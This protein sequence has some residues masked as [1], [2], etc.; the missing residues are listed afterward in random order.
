[1]CADWNYAKY[2]SCHR[3]GASVERAQVQHNGSFCYE[4]AMGWRKRDRRRAAEAQGSTSAASAMDVDG[5]PPAG[6]RD[7]PDAQRAEL[8]SN[9][10]SLRAALG[11]LAKGQPGLVV[12]R[13]G[14]Q[15]QL[16]ELER[17]RLAL[18][19]PEARFQSALD[20]HRAASTKRDDLEGRVREARA[21][22]ADLE[23]QLRAACT[24]EVACG[25]AAEAAR[26]A[27]VQPG[28]PG[29]SGGAP[30]GA[31]GPAPTDYGGILQ[32]VPPERAAQLLAELA[33]AAAAARVPGG[34][35]DG[36]AGAVPPLRAP[37][38]PQQVV[39]P[40][41]LGAGARQA[42]LLPPPGGPGIPPHVIAAA[43]AAAAA[44]GMAERA[45]PSQ[46]PPGFAAELPVED[47]VASME[48]PVGEG[49]R[50]RSERERSPRRSVPP[51]RSPLGGH[52]DPGGS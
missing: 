13:D 7:G 8:D 41:L 27:L 14:L 25:R 29:S 3:C 33:Y 5:D 51:E 24:T 42:G 11:N 40:D 44:P 28:A 45:D 15:E 26:M 47:A 2:S 4:R 18:R 49:E 16:D 35:L 30:A 37:A 23:E 20:A 19:P 10:R 9:I 39:L 38:A 50:G 46:A 34:A 1:M 32:G 48:L 31:A 22:L 21:Q 12:I 6:D 36:P 43:A 17:R 52:S